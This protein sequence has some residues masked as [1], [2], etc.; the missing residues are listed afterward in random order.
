M[1]NAGAA[2]PGAPGAAAASAAPTFLSPN[3]PA[4]SA[5]APVSDAPFA[6][7]QRMWNAFVVEEQRNAA[8][9]ALAGRAAQALVLLHTLASHN[10]NRLAARL[11]DASRRKLGEVVSLLLL[12]H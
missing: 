7:R 12:S 11:D 1:L 10:V 4:P 2:A 5:S 3:P 6:K 8:V 9:R